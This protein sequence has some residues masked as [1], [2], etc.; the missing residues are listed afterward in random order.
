MTK[1]GAAVAL[2][3]GLTAT[4]GAGSAALRAVVDTTSGTVVDQAVRLSI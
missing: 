1:T 3:N 4:A 2:A